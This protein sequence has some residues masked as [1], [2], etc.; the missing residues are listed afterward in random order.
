[1]RI[2]NPIRARSSLQR[3]CLYRQHVQQPSLSRRYSL[4]HD[5]D[6]DSASKSP[7]ANVIYVPSSNGLS[8]ATITAVVGLGMGQSHFSAV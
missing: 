5:L 1:M 6:D 4:K 3:V 7:P 8:D 2:L